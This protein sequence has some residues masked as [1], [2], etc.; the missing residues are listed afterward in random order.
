MNFGKKIFDFLEKKYSTI[1]IFISLIALILFIFFYWTLYS[2]IMTKE[3]EKSEEIGLNE[4]SL[5]KIISNIN[6]REQNYF[7]SLQ[8]EYRDIF[9]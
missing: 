4:S 3:P 8:K 6:L 9:K 5:N 7:Q 1:L 2:N